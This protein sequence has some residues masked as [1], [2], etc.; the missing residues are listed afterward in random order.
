M[1]E[2]TLPFILTEQARLRFS[3]WGTHKSASQKSSIQDYFL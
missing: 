3:K 1:I 2:F